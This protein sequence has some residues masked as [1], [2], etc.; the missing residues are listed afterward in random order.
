MITRIP[1]RK[2]NRGLL[3]SLI[4]GLAFLSGWTG[5]SYYFEKYTETNQR[6]MIQHL[7]ECESGGVKCRL[8]FVPIPAPIKTGG[9]YIIK[10]KRYENDSPIIST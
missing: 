8:Q 4:V 6:E 3:V 7:L 2:T 10:G 1:K 9:V 5:N